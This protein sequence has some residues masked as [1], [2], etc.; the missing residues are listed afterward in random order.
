MNITNNSTKQICNFIMKNVCNT[1]DEF[2]K[3]T[4]NFTKI[5]IDTFNDK[6]IKYDSNDMSNDTSND[7][8]ND[9]S[10]DII[11]FINNTNNDLINGD[12]DMS[13]D[14]DGSR[15]IEKSDGNLNNIYCYQI[16]LLMIICMMV[17]N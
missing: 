3:S 15:S 16:L 9:M 4:L 13:N 10:N 8:S 5:I 1:R 7:I 17:I 12:I 2:N 6:N 11:D 14:I